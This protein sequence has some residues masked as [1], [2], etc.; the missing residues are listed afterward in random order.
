[1]KISKAGIVAAALALSVVSAS[2]AAAAPDSKDAR[3]QP[4]PGN[5]GVMRVSFAAPR[6][7]GG[8]RSQAPAERDPEPRGWAMLAAGILGAISIARRRM[9]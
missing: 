3:A 5:G 6:P 4:A 9:S 2:A 1:M 8:Q 7:G